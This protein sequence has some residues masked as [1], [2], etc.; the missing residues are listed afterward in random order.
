MTNGGKNLLIKPQKRANFLNT[1]RFPTTHKT[2]NSIK[3]G[4]G[5]KQIIVEKTQIAQ[6]KK[7]QI[8]QLY[9]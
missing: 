9:F 5:H 6:V 2:S 3:M 1:Q 4:K 8:A 7:T